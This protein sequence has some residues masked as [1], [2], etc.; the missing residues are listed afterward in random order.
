MGGGRGGGATWTV[1]S[2]AT[3]V[4]S[5]M[6]PSPK[7]RLKS[8]GERSWLSTCRT[9]TLSVVAN[10]AP[11]ARQSCGAPASSTQSHV[12]PQMSHSLAR[13]PIQFPLS[14]TCALKCPT[15]K[16]APQVPTRLHVR[17]QVSHSLART[18][19]KFPLTCTSAHP[20]PTHLHVHPS[21]SHS[22]ARAPIKFPIRSSNKAVRGQAV[23]IPAWIMPLSETEIG[24]NV[25]EKP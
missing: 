17:P 5:L 3:E 20:V 10:I 19:L 16:H 8:S 15:C 2:S 9:A 25:I 22:P 4:A 1:R 24:K 13:T 23:R 21:T 7:T 18:P 12:R 11:S 14:R 6:T